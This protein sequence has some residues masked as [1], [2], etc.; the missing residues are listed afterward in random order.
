MGALY[1]GFTVPSISS[2]L[3]AHL[4]L[5]LPYAILFEY[6]PDELTDG[7]TGGPT[8]GRTQPQRH[9]T[10]HLKSQLLD[11]NSCVTDGPTDA[12]SNRYKKRT[13]RLLVTL[14]VWFIWGLIIFPDRLGNEIWVPKKLALEFG[15]ATHVSVK[16]YIPRITN[17]P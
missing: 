3:P 10:M 9:A 12:P 4:S 16:T 13:T 14:I 6:S 7:C 15:S 5:N 8:D 2:D 1:R 17:T 11:F